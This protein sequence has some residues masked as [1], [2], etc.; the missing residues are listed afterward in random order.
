MTGKTITMP[1]PPDQQQSLFGAKEPWEADDAQEALIARVVFPTG[2]SGEFSYLVSESLAPQLEAGRRVRVPLGRSN[3]LVMG[4]CVS[5]EVQAIDSRALKSIA[6]VVDERTL[7]S[8]AMLRLT[9]WMAERYLCGWGQVLETVLPAGVRFGAGTRMATLVTISDSGRHALGAEKLT[10]KQK[11]ILQLLAQ[12]DKPLAPNEVISTARCTLAPLNAL[13]KRGLVHAQRKRVRTEQT[14]LKQAEQIAAWDL[15]A[16]QQRALDVLLKAIHGRQSEVILLHGVTGSGKTEVYMRAIEEVVSFGR[17]AIVLVPEISLTPQTVERFR[18]RFARVAVLHSH[19]TD[20]ERH[21]YWDEIAAG[22]VQVV[23]GPRSAVFAPVTH[24]GIIILDEEHESTFK[25]ES[26][27]RYH[28]REVALRRAADEG[29]PLILGSATPS[30]ESWQRAREQTYRLVNMPRRVYDRPLPHV[31]TI[32]MLSAQGGRPRRS[33]I[34]APLERAMQTAL[35]DDGQVILLLNRRG[36]ATHI[37]CPMCSLVLRCP[38]CDIAMIHHRQTAI[39][40]CHYCDY[41]MPPPTECPDCHFAGILYSGIGTERLEAEVRQRFPAYPCLRMDTDSVRGAGAHERALQK[42]RSGEVRI[43][44]GTQMIAKGLDFPNVTLVGVVNADT[45]LHLP[46]FRAGERTFQLLAQV[47]GRTGRGEKGGRVLVQTLNPHHP[48]IEFAARHDYEGFAQMELEARKALSY[49]PFGEM[50]RIVVRGA[51]QTQ[52]EDFAQFIAGQLKTALEATAT[53]F[54]ILGP[55]MAPIAKLRGQYRYHLQ[56]QG[57]Q[58]DVLR[59][60]VKHVTERLTTPEDV[61]WIVDIDPM[62]ML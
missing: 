60:Q 58:A 55:A 3:R 34:S 57:E 13:R 9:R 14:V 38:R 29:V 37:Q 49:P 2:A 28:A 31:V 39:A 48:A 8:P 15:N 33:A 21:A 62:S 10:P 42:F 32:D 41:Q 50:V 27:P 53:P 46:D 25:Q 51:V 45:G 6:E 52:V 22:D 17:T 36:F 59:D 7:L 26:A 54:R 56:I 47:A 12:A 18:S 5:L 30:L 35:D 61:Q 4:Y 1:R 40:L 11:E 43:L 23:V 44:L 24:L 19:Q 20:T 16:D